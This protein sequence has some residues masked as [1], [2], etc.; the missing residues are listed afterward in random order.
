M[1]CVLYASDR[2]HVWQGDPEWALNSN[3]ITRWCNIHRKFPSVLTSSWPQLQA[4]TSAVVSCDL[5][6]AFD[7]VRRQRVWCF[8]K[9]GRSIS[10][11]A[12]FTM[13][14]RI[15][16]ARVIG[17]TVDCRGYQSPIHAQRPVIL[18]RPVVG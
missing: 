1:R 14:V 17:H 15:R 16:Q 9:V 18:T 13:N 7:R 5:Y 10:G 8:P 12:H 3:H 2:E 11:P 6:T 4:Y